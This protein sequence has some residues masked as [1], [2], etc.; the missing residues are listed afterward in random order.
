[1][2]GKIDF[3]SVVGIVMKYCAIFMLIFM[4]IDIVDYYFFNSHFEEYIK[5]IAG[6]PFYLFYICIFI[7]VGYLMWIKLKK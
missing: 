5:T 7:I 1:M 6:I 2:K 4:A 3:F